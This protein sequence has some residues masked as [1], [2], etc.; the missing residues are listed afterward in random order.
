MIA[1]TGATGLL[2]SFIVQRLRD[3]GI[4]FVGIK[5]DTTNVKPEL[6]NVNWREADLLD[7][8][9]L[10]NA[11]Q[12][13]N[14]VIHTAAL[15]S[16]NPSD[17]E[18]LHKVNVEGTR[19]IVNTCLSTGVSRLVHISSVAALGRQKGLTII[20]EDSKWIDSNLNSDY[21]ESK[22]LAELEVYRGKEEGLQI[23]ILNPSV[24]L[25][26]SDWNRSSSQLFRYVWKEKAF[27]ADGVINYVDVRDVAE[28]VYKLINRKSSGG[29]YIASAGSVQI[30]EFL[31]G[32]AVLF[33]KKAPRFKVPSY[34]LSVAAQLEYIRSKLTGSEPIVSTQSARAANENFIYNNQKALTELEAEFRTLEETLEWCC[35]YYTENS[36][37]NY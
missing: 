33:K 14:T 1:V 9:A 30:I 18:R 6:A 36:T 3:S 20:N 23:D 27:Y 37:T 12:G 22:Y 4:P 28:L 29:R 32:I 10:E 5:R 24:I 13:V 19:N 7:M 21:A 2:G 15:V 16:F 11:L 17:K 26:R 34:L 35:S 8:A 31:T 25:S